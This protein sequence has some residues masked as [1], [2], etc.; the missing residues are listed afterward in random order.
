MLGLRL[1][2]PPLFPA[3]AVRGP[4]LPTRLAV[5]SKS[6]GIHLMMAADFAFHL[7]SARFVNVL[8]AVAAATLFS[9][10]VLAQD[11]GE[12]P[13]APVPDAAAPAAPEAASP[14]PAPAEAAPSVSEPLPLRR[15]P[16]QRRP[17]RGNNPGAPPCAVAD[18]RAALRSRLQTFRPGESGGAEGRRRAFL[19]RR[20]VRPRSIRIRSKA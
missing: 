8:T 10:A 15:R 6:H 4:S 11:A 2:R 13:A 5:N 14:A 19:R 12:A 9:G 16:M 17:P 18:R 3:V 7:R 1:S 20:H